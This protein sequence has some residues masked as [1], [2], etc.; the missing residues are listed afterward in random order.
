MSV[1]ARRCVVPLAAAGFLAM[2]IAGAAPAAANSAWWH[3]TSGSRPS[4]L[5][6]EGAGQIVVSASNLGDGSA[7]GESSPVVI[8]DRLPE[9]LTA[10]SIEA[11]AGH[12]SVLGAIK[13]SVAKV[14][15]TF[16][17]AVPPYSNIELRIGVKAEDARS[18][19]VNEVTISGGG[20]PSASLHH[21]IT[22]SALAT[23]FGVSDFGFAPENEGGLLDGQAGSHPFQTTFTLTLNQAR[24]EFNTTLGQPEAMPVALPKDLRF[25]LPP[26]LIGNP[27]P[28]PKC[29]LA[30]FFHKP[31]PTCV[32]QTVLGVALATFDEPGVLGLEK[33]AVPV[34]NVEPEA[35]EPARFGFLPTA[36]TPVFIDTAVRS[37]QDYAVEGV[38]N[39][40]T[41]TAAIISSE[42]VLWGVP[43]DPR[44]D[45]SRGEA[46]LQQEGSCTSLEESNPPALFELPT[47]CDGPLKTSVRGDSWLAPSGAGA[48]PLL[49]SFELP[50]LSG[51]NQLPFNPSVSVIPETSA[52]SSATGLTVDVHNPQ[53]IDL[54]GEARREADI[55]DIAVT[56][57]EGMAVNPGGGDGLGACPE[58]LVG[59]E[60][61][62]E[63]PTLPGLSTPTFTPSLPV[64]VLPGVN[65]C[66]EASK[67]ATARIK[68]PLLADPVE[69]AVYLASQNENPFGSLLAMYLVAEDPTAGVVVKLVGQVHLSATGQLTTT[70]EDS[71][72]APFEDAELHFFGG[73]RAPL[74]TPKRCGLYTATASIVPWSA[75]PGDPPKKTEASFAI[76]SGP[77]GSPCPGATLPFAPTL[78]AGSTNVDAG[79]LTAISTTVGR[80]SG[81]QQ[82]TGV[83]VRLPTGLAG[84]L[85]G[86]PLCAEA[87][88]D[89]GTCP[90]ASLIGETTVTAGVGSAS[91][92]V[93]GGRVYLTESYQGAPFGLSIA[94]PVKAGPFDLEHDTANPSQQPA[95]D[96]VVVRAK[97]EIDPRSAEIS[98]TSDSSGPYAIPRVIDGVPVQIQH[99]NVLIN[100]PNFSFNPTSCDPLAVTGE[101]SGDEGAASLAS[102][103]FQLTNCSALGFKPVLSVST[104]A[105]A[106]RANGASLKFKIAYP[107]HAMGSEAWFNET[108]FDLPK[109]L[110]ARLGTIQ[111]ACPA[112]TF[113][114]D[115]ASC[116]AAARIGRAVVHTP[117]LPV[118][119]AGPVYLVSYGGAQFPEAVI[120]LE[121]YGVKVDLH[122][123]TFIHKDTGVTSVTFRKLPDLPFESIE[124]T[125]PSGQYSEFGASLPESANYNFCGQ[126]LIMPTRM[127]AS[128]GLVINENKAVEIEGCR[129]KVLRQRAGH[130]A[131]SLTIAVPGAG[132]LVASGRGVRT[133]KRSISAPQTVTLTLRKSARAG[134]TKAT[135]VHVTY[136]P[137]KG[138]S[139]HARLSVRMH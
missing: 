11:T 120:M 47:S 22:V 6:A 24:G 35:G 33:V 94:S 135:L 70:F 36:Q 19:E 14:T 55:K 132:R 48:L 61:F 108:K 59:F 68:T 25:R 92:T 32:P 67:I 100:R 127:R 104:P 136:T 41:Q 45:A 126:K 3:L 123:E 119:L 129:L 31:S 28:F 133:V 138:A 1:W 72:Q 90:A 76:T 88:A 99:V 17:H 2:S 81:Q 131:V 101:L 78:T 38:V 103:P 39:N 102:V 10:T 42:V 8:T 98:V 118:P 116:N 134:A 69:G 51:C 77:N 105:Q 75:E 58:S 128:N 20:A 113:E 23:P 106:S 4:Y 34:Y 79:A 121:G 124:V 74:A 80:E 46:C 122:G 63:L 139:Q 15:C 53:A 64:P 107:S 7:L 111:K 84:T 52:G 87:Q 21:A 12:H 40:I 85:S 54:D 16:E 117:V 89:A 13:C 96:C 73:G 86:I 114:A 62:E 91:V 60:G 125:V 71:P 29:S 97:V 44:H 66:S 30:Q 26:G 130:R 137:V 65:F 37:G 95:C 43:G 9:G 5:K 49:G 27:N 115:P 112:A 110:P 50:A 57:P 93:P 18:G 109:Q 83:H 82:L 56:L